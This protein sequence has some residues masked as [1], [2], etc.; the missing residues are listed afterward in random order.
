MIEKI[1]C[2][3]AHVLALSNKG[4]LYVWGGNNYGQLGLGM[5]MNICNPVQVKCNMITLMNEN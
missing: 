1:V 2:G 4:A 5:K 3:Y